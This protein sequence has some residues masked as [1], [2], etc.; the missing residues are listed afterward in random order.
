M[1]INGGA[2]AIQKVLHTDP[3]CGFS[4]ALVL[5]TWLSCNLPCIFPGG[6]SP[7]HTELCRETAALSWPSPRVV[8]PVTWRT[9]LQ[10]N[11]I[12]QSTFY[13]ANI[14]GEATLNG[15]TAKSV[16]N[17]KIEENSS[18]PS[19]CI[20]LWTGLFLCVKCCFK[21]DQSQMLRLGHE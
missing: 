4:N 3:H 15:A 2:A 10:T 12:N 8:S 9:T 5:G 20:I 7:S 17:R 18:V 11:N 19:I 1:T 14:S 6:L 21:S 16:I 13:S